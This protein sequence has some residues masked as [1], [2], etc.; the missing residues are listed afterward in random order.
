MG[1]PFAILLLLSIFL[2]ILAI[3][4]VIF[5]PVSLGKSN[6]QNISKENRLGEIGLIENDQERLS[7]LRRQAARNNQSLTS[8]SDYGPAPEGIS[9]GC[10]LQLKPFPLI[11][12]NGRLVKPVID[13][14]R[15]EKLRPRLRN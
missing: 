5:S 12:K 9:E 14:R 7:R 10:F 8:T 6:N 4:Y 11:V 15:L 1:W 3:L 13:K 2:A